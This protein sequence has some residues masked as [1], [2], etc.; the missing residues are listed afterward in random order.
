VC[1]WEK[2][3]EVSLCIIGSCLLADSSY[4]IVSL[5]LNNLSNTVVPDLH[6]HALKGRREKRVIILSIYP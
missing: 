3:K 1:A 2:S 4:P 6:V 5:S